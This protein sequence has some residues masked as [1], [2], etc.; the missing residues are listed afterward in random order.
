MLIGPASPAQGDF[1]GFG[2]SLPPIAGVIRIGVEGRRGPLEDVSRHVPEAIRRTALRKRADRQ[3]STALV[4]GSHQSHEIRALQTAMVAPVGLPRVSPGMEPTIGPPRGLLPLGLGGQAQPGPSAIGL[5]IP[6][7]NADDGMTLPARS[8]VVSPVSLRLIAGVLDEG[9]KLLVGHLVLADPIRAQVE[10]ETGLGVPVFR[11]S[12][13]EATF[14]N[15]D[16]E[17]AVLLVEA[18][19]WG[20]R[21]GGASTRP[22][23]ETQQG[24]QHGTSR[25]WLHLGT[26]RLF[27]LRVGYSHI[28]SPG[29]RH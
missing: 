5:G 3:G 14:R 19:L 28:M 20:R 24:Q 2:L 13:D 29:S 8:E 26:C 4:Q 27:P 23:Q 9:G 18:F 22:Q 21:T 11:R 16:H 1:D 6:P 12:H 25:H 17:R 10:R 15:P 7:G